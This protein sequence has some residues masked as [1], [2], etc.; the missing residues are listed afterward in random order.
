[1]KRNHFSRRILA[2]LLTLLG[3]SACVEE[4]P[5]L[6]GT[7]LLYGPLPVDSAEMNNRQEVP[8]NSVKQFLP[9]TTDNQE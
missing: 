9:S 4:Q 7:P 3:F 1:M 2:G 8:D 6:Y 5:D